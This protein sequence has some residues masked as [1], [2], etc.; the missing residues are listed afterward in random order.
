MPVYLPLLQK[1]TSTQHIGAEIQNLLLTQAGSHGTIF[2][3]TAT[4][5][6]GLPQTY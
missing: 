6:Q 4:K 5:L 1:D 2:P 3:A